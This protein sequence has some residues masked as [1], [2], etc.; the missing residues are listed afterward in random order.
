MAEVNIKAR[1][2]Q[3]GFDIYAEDAFRDENAEII[4]YLNS[5]GKKALVGIQREDGIYTI[6]GEEYV[7]YLTLSGTT[8]EMSLDAFRKILKADAMSLG[9]KGDFQ[10]LKINEQDTVWLKSVETMNAMWNT[11]M[12]LDDINKRKRKTE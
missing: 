8:G 6:V 3:N 10:F 1:I 9:K 4:K 2:E 11:I 7:Y 12:Y 5:I